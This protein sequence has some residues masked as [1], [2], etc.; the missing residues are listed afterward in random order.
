MYRN[1]KDIIPLTL[2][3]HAFVLQIFVSL[4]GKG[5]STIKN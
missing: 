3:M 1:V 2:S 4:I 5:K